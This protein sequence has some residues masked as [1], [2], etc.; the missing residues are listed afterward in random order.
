MNTKK[1]TLSFNLIMNVIKSILSILF[2][3]ITLPYISR[4]LTQDSIGEYNFSLS[5]INY[6]LLISALGIKT[7]A[8]KEGSK[9]RDNKAEFS[10]FASRMFSLNLLFTIISYILLAVSFCIFSS[11]KAYGTA[12]F[13]AAFSIIFSTIGVEWLFNIVED[14]EYIT[15]RSIFV[16]A[17]SLI[18]MFTL[19]RDASD[20]YIYMAISVVA[21]GGANIFNWFYAKRY[22]RIRLVFNRSVFD[23]IVPITVIFFNTLATVIY[24]NSDL[25][26]LGIMSG[27]VE[28][29]VYSVAAKT[30][31]VVKAVLN[32]ILPVYIARLSFEYAGDRERYKRTFRQAADLLTCITIPLA[33]GALFYSRDVILLLS[34]DEY[35]GAKTGMT[36]LFVS[37]IFATLGNLY[38]SGALLLEGREKD[39]LIATA[40]G[41]VANL[42]VNYILIPRFGCTGAAIGTLATEIIVFMIIYISAVRHIGMSADWRG[43]V[44]TII[45][46]A[47]IVPIYM[48]WSRYGSDN[49]FVFLIY[50]FISIVIYYILMLVMKNDTVL[51]VTDK[52]LTKLKR[53]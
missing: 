9:Y 27:P 26:M 13:I 53:R 19:V 8:I 22:C 32:G 29:G 20:A 5:V 18:L 34:T 37:L 11:L 50:V 2:P 21:N 31:N 10:A 16:Q 33:V 52:I 6:F 7:F 48:I 41:A 28:T 38:G 42:S 12:I 46:S 51:T 45:S 14:F 49:R 25:T 15:Y 47:P 23:D 40:I 43:I 1:R 35:L 39:M 44:K 30:Y 24:V 4:V 36:I 3:L 17:V